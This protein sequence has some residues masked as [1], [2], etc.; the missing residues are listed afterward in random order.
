MHNV[1]IYTKN[2]CPYCARA[3]ALLNRLDV[4]FREIDVT[5]DLVREKEMVERAHRTSVP[6]VFVGEHHVGGSDDL[7]AAVAS[8]DV[9]VIGAGSAGLAAFRSAKAWTDNV[10]LIEGGP[11]GT[12]CARVGCMPSKLLIAAA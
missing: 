9:A 8:G 12:T 1:E 3:K 4:P 5:N 11:Y 7:A 2:W 6:Q 10:V